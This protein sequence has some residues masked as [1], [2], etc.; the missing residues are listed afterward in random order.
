MASPQ[1]QTINHPERR[2][3]DG[4]PPPDLYELR[5][6]VPI[7]RIFKARAKPGSEGAIAGK[8]ATTSAELV[9]DQA[10]LLGF[11]ASRP[12]NDAERDFVFATVWRDADALKTFFGQEWRVSLLPPGYSDLIEVCSVEHYYLTE[13]L[14]VSDVT[15]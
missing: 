9:R 3:V 15:R 14:L 2:K 12:A 13:H 6:T 5:P 8:L 7:L 1:S 10:G 4:H 11:L